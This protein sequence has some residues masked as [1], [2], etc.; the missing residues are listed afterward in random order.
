MFFIVEMQIIVFLFYGKSAK[1]LFVIVNKR[2]FV[3]RL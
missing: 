3:C 1:V 2:K